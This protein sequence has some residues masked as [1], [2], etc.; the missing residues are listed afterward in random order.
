[1]QPALGLTSEFGALLRRTRRRAGLSLRD[2]AA[3]VGYSESQLSRLETGHRQPDPAM[4]A[5]RLVPAL[6]LTGSP[7]A[8]ELIGLATRH[9]SAPPSEDRAARQLLALARARPAL[10]DAASLTSWLARIDRQGDALGHALEWYI[11][12]DPAAGLGCVDALHPYWRARGHLAIGQIWVER[13]LAAVPS[14]APEVAAGALTAG[15][16]AYELGDR[17]RAETLALRSL[18]QARVCGDR[19]VAANALDL[20]GRA[21]YGQARYEEAEHRFDA[22]CVLAAELG[23]LPLLA[24]TLQHRAMVAKDCGQLDVADA[25]L[26][27]SLALS[28]A[29]GDR[30]GEAYT[31]LNRSIVAY[32][33]GDFVAAESLGGDALALQRACGDRMGIAYA[34]DQVGMAAFRRGDC[35][36]APPLLNEALALFGAVGDRGGIALIHQELGVVLLAIGDVAGAIA[37]QRAGLALAWAIEDRRRVAFCLEGLAA[38]LADA[39]PAESARLLG[40]TQRLRAL[41]AAPL[42]PS[43]AEAMEAL[44]ARLYG[45]LGGERFERLVVEDAALD[46][47][48]MRQ[49]SQ[50]R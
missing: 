12:H 46:A 16:L 10:D 43:E 8:Q 2:L 1:M 35:G 4:V 32:W 20:L 34:L 5:G 27:R 23:D 19:G 22:C 6:G 50:L 30:S 33:R 13:L 45:A 9:G 17:R 3:A 42:P 25:L 44:R 37:Q 39:E 47:T 24:R 40:A 18:T 28:R 7:A 36:R 41:I 49:L 31:L 48:V 11:R 21:A 14:G 26:L 15:L 29:L 38:A